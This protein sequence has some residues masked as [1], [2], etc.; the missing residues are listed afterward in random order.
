MALQFRCRDV[1]V[2]CRGEVTADD[3][4]QLVEKVKEHAQKAH[5]VE[6]TQTLIDFAKT[7]VHQ[8]D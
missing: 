2:A 7:T 3:A 5:G 8:V 6:L 1:G 4:D